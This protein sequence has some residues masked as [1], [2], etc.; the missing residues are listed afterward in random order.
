[1]AVQLSRPSLMALKR[2]QTTYT[3]LFDAMAGMRAGLHYKPAWLDALLHTQ[4][5]VIPP[6]QK[7]PAVEFGRRLSRKRQSL[8]PDLRFSEDAIRNRLLKEYPH[9]QHSWEASADQPRYLALA[10]SRFAHLNPVD[11]FVVRYGK[12]RT[13]GLSDTEAW[14]R[15]DEQR[16]QDV[17][18][19]NTERA[20]AREQAA[21]A[22]AAALM[23][24]SFVSD[25]WRSR[26]EKQIHSAVGATE[27]PV[28]EPASRGDI[29]DENTGWGRM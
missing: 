19:H 20:L 28:T 26:Y 24:E 17:V 29:D 1:M 3:L 13:L 4:P 23:D 8:P 10:R 2:K 5:P 25:E 6:H 15:A 18:A 14:A 16:R 27:A 22:G 7:R 11:T 12:W 9:L 21:R